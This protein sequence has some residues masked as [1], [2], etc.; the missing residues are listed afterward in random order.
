LLK[1]SGSFFLGLSIF[2]I[3]WMIFSKINN[4]F[5]D[6]I[7]NITSPVF[8]FVLVTALGVIILVHIQKSN[9]TNRL[10]RAAG[11]IFF[12]LFFLIAGLFVFINTDKGQ[13]VLVHAFTSHFSKELNTRINIRHISFS[14]L[15]KM[16]LEGFVIE[17]Q[18]KDT[19]L[20]AGKLQVRITDWFLFKDKAVLEYIGLEDA[21]IKLQRN[22]SVWNYDFLA[23]YFSPSSADTS[24]GTSRLEINLKRIDLKNID[25]FQ[26]DGWRGRDM[27][28][29]FESLNLDAR[30]I[31]FNTKNVD[32]SSIEI[33]N[34]FFS[35]FDYDGNRPDSLHP[36]DDHRAD[37]PVD[38]SLLKW[39]PAEWVVNIESL[40]IKNGIFKNDV[41]TD[42][43]P[44]EFF[45]GRHIDFSAINSEFKNFKWYKD[46]ITT[47]LTISTKE[48]SGFEV[49]SMTAD[50]KVTPQ[51]MTLIG[52]ISRQ[53]TVISRIFL[54][55]GTTI[56]T[57]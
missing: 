23:D 11:F 48:R 12:I 10:L 20:S 9:W 25:L 7:F 46:S 15:N 51:E 57:T 53:I 6:V 21:K 16:N 28:A 30:N 19:M 26:R 34:P 39:N 52:S 31:N 17:D 42:R 44:Y 41:K 56:S 35:I 43:A 32:I 4:R 22:D 55:C 36:K 38:S 37:L 50:A 47:H 24:S 1:I 14:L 45:D 8:W 5:A 13:N 33:D 2:L 3:A 49:K 27:T 40:K 29:K 18:Q 54:P